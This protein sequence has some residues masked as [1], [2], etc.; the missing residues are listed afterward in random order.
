[1]R[2]GWPASG[3]WLPSSDDVHVVSGGEATR[4]LASGTSGAAPARFLRATVMLPVVVPL[5][6]SVAMS[7]A[8][9]TAPGVP[10]VIRNPL[11]FSAV[12]GRV[13]VNAPRSIVPTECAGPATDAV[14]VNDVGPVAT[15]VSWTEPA[16]S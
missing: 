4:R 12:F 11:E 13:V 5:Y 3:T 9:S 7:R 15:I 6:E 14:P 1:S 16:M 2:P 8:A 10:E